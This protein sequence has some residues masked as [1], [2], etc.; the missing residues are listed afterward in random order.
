[1]AGEFEGKSLDALYA[2]IASAKPE[3]ITTTGSGLAAAVPKI[4]EIAA[5]LRLYVSRVQW[6]GEG[7]NAFRTWGA[8]MVS[9]TLVMGDF[10]K[11]VADEMQRAGQALSEAKAAVP[12]PA[13]MCFAD[14]EKEKARI[15]SETG[16]KLQEAIHQMERLSSY[17][18]ST[19]E[20]MG[21]EREPEFKPL[22]GDFY[23]GETAYGTGG[24]GS[25]TTS[26]ASSGVGPVHT[27]RSSTR[28]P[29]VA[30]PSRPTPDVTLPP[31]ATRPPENEVNTNLDSVTITPETPTRPTAQP[32][33]P[34]V[35]T[36]SPPTPPLPP[37]APPVGPQPTA[38]PPRANPGLPGPATG[39]LKGP[40]PLGTPPRAEGITGGRQVPG[41]PGL[42]GQGPR[43]PMG[44]VIGEERAGQ[45]GRG[46]AGMHGPGAGMHGAPG[47]NTG[48]AAGRRLAM[49][50]GGTVGNPTGS[51]GR[52]FTPGGTGLVRPA[53][54]ERNE[55]ERRTN[56]SRPD[57]L[58][59]DEETW[60]SGQRQI[61]PPVID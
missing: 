15:E 1:M 34:P 37:L 39:G 32:P 23:A 43:L 44:Q 17:Y 35:T 25:G 57:Y 14:P 33:T 36:A 52:A 9:E 41:R 51:A 56:R 58:T 20:R 38:G 54:T 13:G 29:D 40:S 46:A 42:P 47:G 16:P 11:V 61:V 27:D 2:M 28:T 6:E 60:A 3:E 26:A 4:L 50:P 7:G 22:R 53:S 30:T 18:D 5:D 31:A 12:K 55:D 19:R 21:A 8:G 49:Q 24:S 45:L 59:E 10:T 48:G